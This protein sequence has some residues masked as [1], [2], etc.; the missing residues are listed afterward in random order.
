[1]HYKDYGY[2]SAA[3][4]LAIWLAFS[5]VFVKEASGNTD[6]GTTTNS[7]VF[8]IGDVPA[9]PK[10]IN[11]PTQADFEKAK[12]AFEKQQKEKKPVPKKKLT[13]A[14]RTQSDITFKTGY[15]QCVVYARKVTGDERVK[16]LARTIKPNSQIPA[17]GSVVVTKESLPGKNTGHV[18][19]VI[20]V[21]DTH[22]VLEEANYYR[23]GKTNVSVGRKLALNS[24]LIVGYLIK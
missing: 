2:R 4:L 5:L 19:V 11:G 8:R 1:M 3:V 22:I 12:I 15:Y 6:R 21:T 23:G 20:E 13:V 9:V 16:G 24:T 18:A 7:L 10:P 14:K 17:V